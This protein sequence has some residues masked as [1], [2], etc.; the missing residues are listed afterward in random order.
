MFVASKKQIG[1][2]FGD[3]FLEVKNTG[4]STE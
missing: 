2:Y 4:I 3:I 1:R